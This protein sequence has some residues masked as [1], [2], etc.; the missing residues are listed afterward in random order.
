[1]APVAASGGGASTL[2]VVLV[3]LGATVLGALIVAGAQ[4]WQEWWRARRDEARD[5]T[6]QRHKLRA[7]Y[8]EVYDEVLGSVD[9]YL[10]KATINAVYT[11]K[12]HLRHAAMGEDLEPD[13]EAAFLQSV[14]A[15]SDV[16]VALRR[17][18]FNAPSPVVE[19]TEG[20]LNA[21]VTHFEIANTAPVREEV[22]RASGTNLLISVDVWRVRLE[23]ALKASPTA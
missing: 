8:Q 1:M 7:Q 23:A 19:A 21:L 11:Q 20:T 17:V 13:E 10:R 22:L 9:E 18:L 16:R 5:E 15:M 14:E 12:R 6:E 4:W 2:T 3:G